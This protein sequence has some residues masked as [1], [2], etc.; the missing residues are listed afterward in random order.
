MKTL[1]YLTLPFLLVG[2][3]P[4]KFSSVEIK[5]TDEITGLASNDLTCSIKEN[6]DIIAS[7]QIKN[8]LTKVA[9]DSQSNKSYRAEIT[10][11]NGEAFY[12]SNNP[13]LYLSFAENVSHEI[14]ISRMGI[15]DFGLNAQ[16]SMSSVSDFLEYQIIPLN[17][18]NPLNKEISEGW[19]YS[20]P[21]I[22]GEIHND[23][24]AQYEVPAGEYR[25]DWRTK[26]SGYSSQGSELFNVVGK[27]TT[28]FILNY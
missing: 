28:S 17:Y 18:S 11:N 6:G 10:D 4:S 19:K 3:H 24:Y 26:I 20:D 22:Y 12:I 9:Y 14:V 16:N 25:I 21:D 13:S 2:C 8:G 23:H 15:L 27:D 5:A 7:G 1:I